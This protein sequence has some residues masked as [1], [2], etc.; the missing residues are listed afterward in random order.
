M[1]GKSGFNGT[2]SADM[3]GD[4]DGSAEQ[5]DKYYKGNEQAKKAEE[6]KKK[7]DGV[8]KQ[9]AIHSHMAGKGGHNDTASADMNG[10]VNASSDQ[11]DKYYKGD[12]KSKEEKQT[13]EEKR[14]TRAERIKTKYDG[15]IGAANID[16][17]KDKNSEGMIGSKSDRQQYYEDGVADVNYD[18]IIGE[19]Q[20]LDANKSG[21]DI[22]EK[23]KKSKNVR[24]D[25]LDYY[26]NILDDQ[27]YSSEGSDSNKK[28]QEY[29]DQEKKKKGYDFESE[30]GARDINTPEFESDNVLEGDFTPPEEEHDLD[31]ITASGEI[32][33]II[34]KKNAD[35]D[36]VKYIST[37]EDLY[38]PEVILNVQKGIVSEDE[39]I[40]IYMLIKYL[41]HKVSLN[42]TGQ[43]MDVEPDEE[44]DIITIELTE[45]NQNRIER[46]MDLYMKRQENIAKFLSIAKGY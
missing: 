21:G 15:K 46:F 38:L 31:E 4:V 41:E 37:F 29:A 8:Y 19:K 27:E 6:K 25:R 44:S 7:E 32:K 43:V 16:Q 2:A 24:E 17:S 20:I 34:E 18:S 5:I 9:D 13:P 45:Y 1:G 28:E 22:G 10:D 23:S 12:D 14:A 42:M 39:D 11:I 33:V 40:G 35:G 26:S 30:G 36:T 3:N